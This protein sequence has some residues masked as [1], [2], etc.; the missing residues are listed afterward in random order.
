MKHFLVSS[1]VA[2]AVLS[3][4]GLAP[5]GGSATVRYIPT[6]HA[7]APPHQRAVRH[8]PIYHSPAPPL[9]TIEI[10]TTH[11]TPTIVLSTPPAASACVGCPQNP[12]ANCAACPSQN[13]TVQINLVQVP[14]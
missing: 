10:G 3:A 12:P 9:Q 8:I 1:L 7:A 2:C 13:Q 4:V 5:A 6:T 11:P 14:L